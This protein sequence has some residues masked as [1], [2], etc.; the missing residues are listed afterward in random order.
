MEGWGTLGSSHLADTRSHR[1]SVEGW[2]SP[3]S[4]LFI[5]C[6]QTSDKTIPRNPSIP[7][8]SPQ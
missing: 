2:R 6:F 4:E 7:L 8:K 1:S 5:T 3:G